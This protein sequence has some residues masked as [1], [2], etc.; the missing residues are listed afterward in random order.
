[1]PEATSKPWASQIGPLSARSTN[2]GEA[3][4][5]L[6][7]AVAQ[8]VTSV[9]GMR[10]GVNRAEKTL[11]RL[12][13]ETLTMKAVLAE[14]YTEL[15][16]ID[17]AIALYEE[18]VSGRMQILDPQRDGLARADLK[19]PTPSS[20]LL[21]V[22]R[23]RQHLAKLY[24]LVGRSRD[25][26]PLLELALQFFHNCDKPNV[27]VD[28]PNAAEGVRRLLITAY[29]NEG[30]KRDTLPLYEQTIAY[31]ENVC[32]PDENVFAPEYLYLQITRSTYLVVQATLRVQQETASL[33]ATSEPRT[34]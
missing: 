4:E 17:E 28:M 27:D 11:G 10:R 12:H 13:R 2:E 22:N 9:H 3:M 30:R 23:A 1:M 6:E 24:L 20:S 7:D 15:G 8:Y 34:F 29:N 21:Q 16:R 19:D 18:V 14:K 25:A 26:I 5:K 31:F 32:G 33:A